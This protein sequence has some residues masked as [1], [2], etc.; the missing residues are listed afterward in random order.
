MFIKYAMIAA[1]LLLA[2]TPSMASE[3]T[4]NTDALY[5]AQYPEYK[6]QEDGSVILGHI[7][8]GDKVTLTSEKGQITVCSRETEGNDTCK[9]FKKNS[10]ICDG[11]GLMTVC[12]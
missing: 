7:Q 5:S 10:V 3:I 12:Q 4:M 9:V 1:M 11:R 8:A 2:T 6:K